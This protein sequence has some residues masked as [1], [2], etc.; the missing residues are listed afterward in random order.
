MGVPIH[1][2]MWRFRIFC[3]NYLLISDLLLEFLPSL[4]L[5][6]WTSRS[7]RQISNAFQH[8]ARP[9]AF[10]FKLQTFYH[11]YRYPLRS[12][13]NCLTSWMLPYQFFFTHHWCYASRFSSLFSKHHWRRAVGSSVQVPNIVRNTQRSCLQVFII[14]VATAVNLWA[15]FQIPKISTI[16]AR[17]WDLLFNLPKKLKPPSKIFSST[18]KRSALIAAILQDLLFKFRT[19]L[20]LCF[21]IFSSVCWRFTVL[22]TIL[23]AKP[24]E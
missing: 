7:T 3:A 22:D 21:Q 6:L 19:L 20:M 2:L 16:D 17:P 24:W 14:I 11:H 4:M 5:R 9:Q 18:F 15:F 10:P 13:W 1:L 8:W 12:Y 23:D